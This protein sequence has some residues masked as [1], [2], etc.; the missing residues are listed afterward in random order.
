MFYFN[1][2]NSFYLNFQNKFKNFWS[3]QFLL[4]FLSNGDSGAG[5]VITTEDNQKYIVGVVSFGTTTCTSK[6][7]VVL[8]KVSNYIDWMEGKF[9][10]FEN[11]TTTEL[12]SQTTTPNTGGRSFNG[13]FR[14][15]VIVINLIIV[16]VFLRLWN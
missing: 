11:P 6:V 7:P 10:Y 16:N 12:K 9:W 5:A 4:K 14:I 1:H 15:L 2:Q 8:T 13:K 3:S